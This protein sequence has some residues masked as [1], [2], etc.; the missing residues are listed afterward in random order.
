L[1][2]VAHSFIQ[3]VG[4]V[5]D[6]ATK[7]YVHSAGGSR[8]FTITLAIVVMSKYLLLYFHSIAGGGG[9]DVVAEC[10]YRL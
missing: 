5:G 1:R 8:R 9:G 4:V 7:H 10:R 6:D 2:R 3:L